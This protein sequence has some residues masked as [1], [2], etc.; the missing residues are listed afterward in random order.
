MSGHQIEVLQLLAHGK[1]N[2]VMG[3]LLGISEDGGKVQ[4]K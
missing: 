1:S 4:V 3:S 2:T